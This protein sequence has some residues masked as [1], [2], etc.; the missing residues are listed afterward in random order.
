MAET[1]WICPWKICTHEQAQA[2]RA[3]T[4]KGCGNVPSRAQILIENLRGT[5]AA[6]RQSA[7]LLRREGIVHA[8]EMQ[9]AANI[10]DSWIAGIQRIDAASPADKQEGHS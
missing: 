2:C 10:I 4:R 1:E 9:G 6:M 8:G 5:Q 3:D 7:A